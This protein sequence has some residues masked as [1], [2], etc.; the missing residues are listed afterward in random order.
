MAGDN[1]HR[2]QELG[3][4]SSLE[5]LL[6]AH[7][8]MPTAQ[9]VEIAAILFARPQHLSAEQVLSQALECGA[10][11]SKAT[12]YNTLGLFAERGLV[13][14][15]I[16]DPAKVFYDSNT[17]AHYHL[18]DVTTGRL[19]DISPSKLNLGPL[20]ELP[21]D[22]QVEGIDVVVRVRSTGRPSGVS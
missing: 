15:V 22:V 21:D 17:S 14:E 16:V 8:I 9:R 13:G 20:P 3:A 10:Q 18:Y 11:V 12:V 6:R 4:G 5:D 1:E 2:N 19:D 7:D